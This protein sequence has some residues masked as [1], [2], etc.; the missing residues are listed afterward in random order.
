MYA[1]DA[2]DPLEKL[3]AQRD[4]A[5]ERVLAPI[6]ARYI[7]ELEKLIHTLTTSNLLDEALEVKGALDLVKKRKATNDGEVKSERLALLQDRRND[8]AARATAPIDETYVEE[9]EQ[10]LRNATS[11]AQLEE[12]VKIRNELDRLRPGR[13]LLGDS[14]N[15]DFTVESLVGTKWKLERPDEE[16]ML[17]FTEDRFLIY[18]PDSQGVWVA[19]GYRI[20]EMENAK[21]RQ[22]RIFWHNGELVATVSNRLTTIKDAKNTMSRIEH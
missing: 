14:S 6:D 18:K 22:I 13:A 20:W 11:S 4:T 10:M 8:A 12:A 7:E 17:E 19:G 2:P 9:L 5:T 1:N 15:K 16:I 3:K 21:R